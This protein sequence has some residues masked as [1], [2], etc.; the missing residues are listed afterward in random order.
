MSEDSAVDMPFA[1][2]AGERLRAGEAE[3]ERRLKQIGAGV[4]VALVHIVILAALLT[5]GHLGILATKAPPKEMVLLLPMLQH[6]KTETLPP[7]VSAPVPET[8]PE[9]EPPHTITLPQPPK[10]ETKPQ[11]PSDVMQAIGKELAC[12]AGSYEHL[13]QTEREECKRHPWKYKKDSKGVIVL[14]VPKGAE[15]E[16]SSM[17]GADAELHIQQTADPCV[18]AGNT[19]TECIHRTLFGR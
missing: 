5:A 15:P 13:S 1:L 6:R 10:A 16:G 9:V 2:I 12:G 19:H 11:N 8:R 3:R 18:A 7:P 14:D 17:S 4:A